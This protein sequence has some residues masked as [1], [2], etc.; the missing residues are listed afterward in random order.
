MLRDCSAGNLADSQLP[1]SVGSIP[2]RFENVGRVLDV[3]WRLLSIVASP[4]TPQLKDIRRLLQVSRDSLDPNI[5][6][7]ARK[8]VC[9]VIQPAL[10]NLLAVCE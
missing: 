5:F 4:P 7:I 8:M 2:A 6:S 9:R 10:Q 3:C 1:S